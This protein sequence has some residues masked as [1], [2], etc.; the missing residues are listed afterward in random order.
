M[1]HPH[2]K[3]YDLFA[4]HAWYIPGMGE[5]LILLALLVLGFLL[6]SGLTQL[7]RLFYSPATV[8]EYGTLV[9]YPAMFIPPLI[10][11]GLKSRNASA[12]GESVPLDSDNWGPGKALLALGVILATV[13]LGYMSDALNSLL[14]PM[15]QWLKEA[16]ELVTQGNFWLNFLCVS[17]MAPLF[18]EWLCRGIVLRGL[19]HHTRKD[20]TVLKPAAAIALSAAFFALIH[21]NPWQALPAF[22]LGCL[23]G[24][25][26]W[27]TGSLKLTMLM[28]FTNNTVSLV[29]A[30][31]E[32]FQDA[33]TWMDILPAG[34]YWAGF[35]VAGVFLYYFVRRVLAR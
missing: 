32:S 19:L 16:M 31:V 12:F 26:Y 25:V 4:T 6:G 9:S 24:L 1:A 28:H 34:I 35:A 5:L 11:V 2:N 14:P 8:L 29:L 18:E 27:K 3:N 7:M 21:L 20:G 15:P 13:A 23:F 33:E 17:I 22:I 30:N 10:Y